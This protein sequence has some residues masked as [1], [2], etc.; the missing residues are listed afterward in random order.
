VYFGP[1]GNSCIDYLTAIS[2]TQ[3]HSKDTSSTG[4][5]AP[6]VPLLSAV[7]S[8]Q[9][10]DGSVVSLNPAEWLV[11]LFTQADRDGRGTDFADVYDA[12]QLKQVRTLWCSNPGERLCVAQV[13]PSSGCTCGR[14][15][16]TLFCFPSLRLPAHAQAAGM[17][18]APC[19]CF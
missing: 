16:H 2:N 5:T 15:T 10:A 11:D 4:K 8:Q 1:T 12:S 18:S 13:V 7:Q 19:Q 6:A 9:L 14:P 17:H 3:L